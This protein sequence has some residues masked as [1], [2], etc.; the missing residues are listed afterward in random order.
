MLTELQHVFEGTLRGFTT[1]PRQ[2]DGQSY[3]VDIMVVDQGMDTFRIT[4]K[5]ADAETLRPTLEPGAVIKVNTL[6]RSFAS[7]LGVSFLGVLPVDKNKT[8]K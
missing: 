2:K 5:R 3:N 6:I 8:V 4:M 1:E 7:G